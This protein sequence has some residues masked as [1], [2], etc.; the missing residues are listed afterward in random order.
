MSSSTLQPNRIL[1]NSID[2]Q[3]IGFYMQIPPWFPVTF[4]SVIAI[5]DRQS[6]A[7]HEMTNRNAQFL[8][9][10]STLLCL[11]DIA[12]KLTRINQTTHQKPNL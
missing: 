1:I 5:R 3:P 11:F 2:Q 9:I 6:I 10:F 12:L 7:R 4:K 8:H